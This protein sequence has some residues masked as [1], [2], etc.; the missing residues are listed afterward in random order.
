VLIEAGAIR[1]MELDINP[2]WV[3]FSYYGATSAAD[4][5]PTMRYGPTHWLA[6]SA[7]DFFAVLV[8]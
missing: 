8:R 5:L 4:L 3:A 7:R 6:G 1:A 2:Q